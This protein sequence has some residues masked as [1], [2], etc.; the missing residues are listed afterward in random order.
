M[1]HEDHALED[2][3]PLLPSVRNINFDEF[4]VCKARLCNVFLNDQVVRHSA[5]RSVTNLFKHHLYGLCTW[6][7][8]HFDCERRAQAFCWKTVNLV[9]LEIDKKAA[10]CYCFNNVS[11]SC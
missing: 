5:L 10:T 6:S 4:V 3:F 2:H 11:P 8:A 7:I 9:N 1:D